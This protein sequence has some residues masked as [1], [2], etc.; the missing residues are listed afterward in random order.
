MNWKRLLCAS[1]HALQGQ[2]EMT[3]VR[4]TEKDDGNDDCKDN[5][6]RLQ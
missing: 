3:T 2:H 1:G 6:T 5:R 4:T